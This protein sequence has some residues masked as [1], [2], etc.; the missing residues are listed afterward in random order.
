MIFPT[1]PIFDFWN[2]DLEYFFNYVLEFIRQVGQAFCDVWFFEMTLQFGAV[3][4]TTTLGNLITS[5]FPVFIVL[6]L[7]KK[8]IPLA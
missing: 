3:V 6:F 8:F 1:T 4:Y 7:V 5:L 2:F